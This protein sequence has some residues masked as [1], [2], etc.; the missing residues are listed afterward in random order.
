[1]MN[2]DE[3]Y[4]ARCVQI[5]QNGR[6]SVAP[7]PMVGAVIVYDDRIIGEGW[8]RKYGGPHAEVNAV[9][10]VADEDVPLLSQSTLY[11]SLEPCSHW[12][13]TPPCAEM[14]VEKG[15]RRVVVGCQDPNEKVQ[16]RGIQ[17]LRDAGIEVKV[18]VL[19]EVC[20]ELNAPFMMFHAQHRPWITLKWAESADGYIDR[21]RTSLE[22]GAPVKF[23]DKWQQ[24]WVHRLRAQH[25]AILVGR[26][27]E[28]LDHPQLTTRLWPGKSPQKV[29]L[30]HEKYTDLPTLLA[31]LYAENIQSLLVEGGAETLQ[32]F[33][34]ADLWDEAYIE[35]SSLILKDGVSAPKIENK[36]SRTKIHVNFT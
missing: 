30:S 8:H 22:D 11:V 16:G 21:C 25:Q 29:V 27:T 9:A 2:S 14:I 26:H 1:M 6:F 19:E 10:A 13:K 24:I 35:K 12:G 7:N 18:G 28:E 20:R 36:S 34:D 32:S 17:R 33:I 15:F 31:D 5:A 4:M 3:K 23:S